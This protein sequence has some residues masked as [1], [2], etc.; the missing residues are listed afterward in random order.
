MDRAPSPRLCERVYNSHLRLPWVTRCAGCGQAVY[1]SPTVMHRLSMSRAPG[2][3]WQPG[4]YA[5]FAQPSPG[6]APPKTMPAPGKEVRFFA[7][8]CAAPR[9]TGIPEKNR[10]QRG[11]AARRQQHRSGATPAGLG[12]A[13]KTHPGTKTL[14]AFQDPGG[15]CCGDIPRLKIR[16][17]LCSIIL[18]WPGT[19]WVTISTCPAVWALAEW[20]SF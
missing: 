8:P 9:P 3:P 5:P 7:A 1:N 12:P 11:G 10:N 6:G 2:Y 20:C 15:Y 18:T 16:T 17:V 4:S 13:V 14:A 19:R